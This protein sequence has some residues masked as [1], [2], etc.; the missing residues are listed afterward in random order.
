MCEITRR[1]IVE[2][3]HIGGQCDAQ[4]ASLDQV[5]RQQGVLRE[6]TIQQRVEQTDL[7]YAFAG[8]TPFTEHVL[9]G[10]GHR[11]G[12]RIDPGWT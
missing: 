1:V 8:E 5:V 4:E 11:P 12:I 6:T 7:V 3:L 10:V 2:H 9:I